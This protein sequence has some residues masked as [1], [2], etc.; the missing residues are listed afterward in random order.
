[1]LII[2][3]FI[4]TVEPQINLIFRGELLEKKQNMVIT[5]ETLKQKVEI[6]EKRIIRARNERDQ[7]QKERQQV[8]QERQQVE[9]ERDK[10][11]EERDEAREELRKLQRLT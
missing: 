11:L 5:L 9:R 6:M 4:S 3:V 2:P 1:M 7:V 8:E 10:A